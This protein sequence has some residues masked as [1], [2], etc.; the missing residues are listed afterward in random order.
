MMTPLPKVLLQLCKR[1]KSLIIAFSQM[2]IDLFPYLKLLLLLKVV[3]ALDYP[4]IMF[5]N[6]LF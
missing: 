4:L 6:C 3:N 1:Q 2:F 5:G